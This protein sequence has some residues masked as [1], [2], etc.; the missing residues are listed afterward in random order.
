MNQILH[1]M[2]SNDVYDYAKYIRCDIL[3]LLGGFI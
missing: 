2:P 1:K 3:K